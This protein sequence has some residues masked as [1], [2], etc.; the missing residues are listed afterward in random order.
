M[1][2]LMMSWDIKPGKEGEYFEFIVREFAPQLTRM[3]IQ[4]VEAWYTVFGNGPQIVTGGVID[5]LETLKKILESDEWREL[6]SEL[7]KFITNYQQKVVPATG[8]FQ[9]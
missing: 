5:D 4:I 2:K 8:R 9:L 1:F 7:M 6:K 3:G